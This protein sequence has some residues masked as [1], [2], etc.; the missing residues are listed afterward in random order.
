MAKSDIRDYNATLTPAQ[1]RESAQ[2]A[3]AASAIARQ[4]YKRQR[5]LIKQVLAAAVDDVELR[6]KLKELGFD[7]TF[8]SAM[9]FAQAKKALA[10]DTEAARY[11]RDTVGE[12]PTEAYQLAVTDQ[13]IRS[14]DLATLS[15]AELEALADQADN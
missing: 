15:D 10:G 11:L 4:G 6:D 7:T 13:P 2:R 5:D 9:V 14:L 8:G 3:A 1:R 12:K